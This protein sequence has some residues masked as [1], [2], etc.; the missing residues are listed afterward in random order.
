MGGGIV[1]HKEGLEVWVGLLKD[2]DCCPSLSHQV[3]IVKVS[4]A[5]CS[6]LEENASLPSAELALAAYLRARLTLEG[7]SIVQSQ[8]SRSL[9]P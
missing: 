1:K 4:F 9:R 5:A 8:D 2:G 3:V 7:L 6:S